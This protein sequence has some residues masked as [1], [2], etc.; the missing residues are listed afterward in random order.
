MAGQVLGSGADGD[1]RVVDL[2]TQLAPVGERVQVDAAVDERLRK[3][4]TT[5]LQ[6]VRA[7]DQGTVTFVRLE[8]LQTLLRRENVEEV[9]D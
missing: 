1:G 4:T 5:R 9:V 6:G 2:E 7:D 3:V 8:P